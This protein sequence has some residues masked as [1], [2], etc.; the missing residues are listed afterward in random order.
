MMQ[1]M[2]I[3]KLLSQ[4]ETP[5]ATVLVTPDNATGFANIT[6]TNEGDS[7]TMIFAN[8]A[9]HIHQPS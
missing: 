7:A 4:T 9:W 3:L 2:E 1:P 8:G 5:G 6:F